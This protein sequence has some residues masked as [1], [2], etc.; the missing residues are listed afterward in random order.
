MTTE[1]RMAQEVTPV[2]ERRERRRRFGTR[3]VTSHADL[4]HHRYLLLHQRDW[5]KRASERLRA[6]AQMLRETWELPEG[7]VGYQRSKQMR[8]FEE[9]L[10]SFEY[11]LHEKSRIME[12]AESNLTTTPLANPESVYTDTFIRMSSLLV[13]GGSF[14]LAAALL[15]I[16][17][18]SLFGVSLINIFAAVLIAFASPFFVW[19]G[20]ALRTQSVE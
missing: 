10:K 5:P 17:S 3:D 9:A 18:W 11:I 20:R 1:A 6:E 8:D 19:M 16:I 15:S 7:D 14:C 12:V 4:W 2:L 13:Y